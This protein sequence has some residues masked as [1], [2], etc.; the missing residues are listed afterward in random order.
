MGASQFR[1]VVVKKGMYESNLL[2]VAVEKVAH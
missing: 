2:Q 1:E